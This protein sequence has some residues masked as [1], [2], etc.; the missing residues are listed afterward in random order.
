MSYADTFIKNLKERIMESDK[1]A[2]C[3]K[4]HRGY[5][6]MLKKM[7][8]RRDP[9]NIEKSAK[10]LTTAGRKRIKE[11]NF[12]LPGGRYPIH[13]RSH[14]RAAL[15]MVAKHGTPEEQA[16]VRAKVKAKYPGIGK[17]AEEI[18]NASF[19]DELKK[20]AA[21]DMAYKCPKC[22]YE[23]N[24]PGKC[25]KCDAMMVK[26]G[27][28]DMKKTAALCNPRKKG[29]AESTIGKELKKQSSSLGLSEEHKKLLFG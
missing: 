10:V 6:M 23:G 22:G 5:K 13:D 4:N 14:A 11:K 9:D 25:P 18:Y 7:K 17:T 28:G 29:K 8:K 1:V 26:K 19:Q 21:E 27:N 15:S 16:T 24:K 3:G 12:A 2:H 20:I